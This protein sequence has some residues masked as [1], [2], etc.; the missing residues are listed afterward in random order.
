[1]CFNISFTKTAEYIASVY[2]MELSEIPPLPEY[3]N[4]SGFARP[5]VPVLYKKGDDKKISLMQWG[6]IPRW[7]RTPEDAEKISNKTLNARCETASRLPSFRCS[8]KTGRCIVLTDGFYEPHHPPGGG[9]PVTYYISRGD[10]G[11]ISLGG[12]YLVWKNPG[13][14][15]LVYSFAVLTC[16]ANKLLEKIHNRKKRMPVILPDNPS[17]LDLWLDPELSGEDLEEKYFRPR[18]TDILEAR[19]VAKTGVDS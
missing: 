6:L 18:E 19:A 1:M 2:G 8:F 5:R 17:M 13:D 11:V 4:A 15:G 10:R 7:I 9:R 16:P 3:S 12:L 14:S